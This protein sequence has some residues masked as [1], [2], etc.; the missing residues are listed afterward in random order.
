MPLL[1]KNNCLNLNVFFPGPA[2]KEIRRQYTYIDKLT[3]ITYNQFSTMILFIG[4]FKLINHNFHRKLDMHRTFD[5]M[6]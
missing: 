6:I 2:V 5:I 4:H 3:A 1:R